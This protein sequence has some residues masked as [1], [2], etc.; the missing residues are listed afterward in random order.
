MKILVIKDKEIINI[1]DP[2]PVN[3]P[4]QGI[5]PDGNLVIYV[6]DLDGLSAHDYIRQTF[7]NGTALEQRSPPPSDFCVWNGTAWEVDTAN[8]LKQVRYNRDLTLFKT[9]WTQLPDAPLT[10]EQVAESATYRQALR[11]MTD[12]IVANPQAYV[13]IEDAPWPTPPSFLNVS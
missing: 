3:N 13:N 7:W 6:N 1:A 10:S 11:D 2:F 12:A 8:Y 9:D 4:E 5:Q